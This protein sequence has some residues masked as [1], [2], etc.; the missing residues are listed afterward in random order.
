MSGIEPI[1]RLVNQLSKLP[2]VGQKTAQRLAYYIISLPEEQ[3]REL[4]RPSCAWC[5]TPGTWPPWSGC[6]TTRGNITCSTA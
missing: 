2:G 6:G 3:V 1:Q 5:G 4:T